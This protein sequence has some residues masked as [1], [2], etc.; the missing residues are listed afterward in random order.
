VPR[1]IAEGGATAVTGTAIGYPLPARLFASTQLSVYTHMATVKRERLR[2]AALR[3][4][5]IQQEVQQIY[6]Q[7]P[8]LERTRS[9]APSRT[10]GNAR[11]SMPVV[12]TY[13]PL[14]LH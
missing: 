11:D 13:R 10:I 6:R 2:A 14:K 5:R 4:Q 9:N 1:S 7:Y 12:S 3:L 8:E